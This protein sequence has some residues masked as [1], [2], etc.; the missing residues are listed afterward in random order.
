ME[1]FIASRDIIGHN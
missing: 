1:K